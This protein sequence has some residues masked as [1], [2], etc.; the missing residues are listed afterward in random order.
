M[1]RTTPL[2]T[3]APQTGNSRLF[4]SITHDMALFCCHT[5]SLMSLRNFKKVQ[6]PL[7]SEVVIKSFSNWL[8]QRAPY[9]QCAK[10][11]PRFVGAYF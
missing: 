5:L 7:S 11:I 9:R 10:V 3:L 1:N 2:P 4:A 8:Q 6:N